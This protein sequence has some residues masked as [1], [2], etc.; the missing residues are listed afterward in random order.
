MIAVVL[1]EVGYGAGR[2]IC[3]AISLSGVLPNF[4]FNAG[5]LCGRN[6]S[7]WVDFGIFLT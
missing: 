4:W 6:S 3:V 5:F 7:P 1:R 2:T